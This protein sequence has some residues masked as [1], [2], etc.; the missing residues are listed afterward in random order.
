MR[1]RC[2]ECSKTPFTPET[3]MQPLCMHAREGSS[4]LGT[5]TQR[6]KVRKSETRKVAEVIYS[7]EFF[8]NAGSANQCGILP[9]MYV[10]RVCTVPA[11]YASPTPFSLQLTQSKC[12]RAQACS[13][14]QHH[15]PSVHS[16]LYRVNRPHAL[17]VCLDCVRIFASRC[18]LP[19]A[20]GTVMYPNGVRGVSQS[21]RSKL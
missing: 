2:W 4:R 6:M 15:K 9:L 14:L 21:N 13:D 3:I 18:P 5:D 17:L 11:L 7:F 8:Q 10:C 12:I 20:S 19:L 16:S 1:T